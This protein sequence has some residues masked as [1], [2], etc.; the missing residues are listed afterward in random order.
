MKAK[1]LI[2]FVVLV[3]MGLLFHP[4]C[5]SEEG[6]EFSILGTWSININIPGWDVAPPYSWAETLTFS[7]TETTGTITGW[8]YAPGQT[9]TYTVTNCTAVT[10]LFNYVDSYWG[11]TNA[12]F[13][14]TLTSANTM[15][16]NGSWDDDYGMFN[17]TWMGTKVM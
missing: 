2:S 16:G 12:N 9:G 8:D 3:V 6:C 5:K 14:G 13:T 1:L 4:A 10:F 17:L 11:P 7:G 15:N